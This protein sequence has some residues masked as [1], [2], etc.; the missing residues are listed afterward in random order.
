[1]LTIHPFITICGDTVPT[2]LL[3]GVA[4]LTV[5]I[6]VAIRLLARLHALRESF[7]CMLISV[8]VI[9]LGGRAFSA[10]SLA[11]DQIVHTGAVTFA[12]VLTKG[13]IVYWGGLIAYVV[14]VFLVCRVRK[15]A[16]RPVFDVLAVCIPLFHSIARIG[17]YCAGCCYGIESDV[18]G[19]P[20]RTSPGEPMV[21]RIP[22]QLIEAAFESLLAMVLFSRFN[23]RAKTDGFESNGPSLIESYFASYACFRFVIEFLRGDAIRG[24]Y[25]G[26]SFSQYVSLIV[27]IVM[28][29]RRYRRARGHVAGID[30]NRQ[31]RSP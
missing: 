17:C 11:I 3:C 29:L 5:S 24:V 12:S 16:I 27:L 22:V 8:P 23:D 18:F 14:T 25:F 6:L 21:S 10:L 15:V 28:A 2:Y 20:Y 13:G 19:L 31:C 9:L 30:S 1:M 4:G 7:G 26:L